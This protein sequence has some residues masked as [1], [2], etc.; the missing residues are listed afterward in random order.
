M[1]KQKRRQP[2]DGGAKQR[3]KRARQRRQSSVD[4]TPTPRDLVVKR[5]L[6][7]VKSKHRS[8]FELV[9]NTEKKKKLECLSTYNPNPPPGFEYVPMGNPELTSLCKELSREKDLLIYIVSVGDRL[10]D[11]CLDRRTHSEQSTVHR[12][13]LAAHMTRCGYHFEIDIVKEA[14]RNIIH[15]PDLESSVPYGAPE[16]IPRSQELYHAQVNA[17]MRDLFPRIPHTDRRIIIDRAF[18]RG[19]RYKGDKPVGLIDDM[20]LSRRI[21]LAVLAHIRHTYTTYD[22]LLRDMPWSSARRV[23]QPACLDVIVKWRGDE[24][25]G[26]DELDEILREVVIISDSEDD[27]SDEESSDGSSIVEIGSSN[28][29]P[30]ACPRQSRAPHPPTQSGVDADGR[31][32]RG[33]DRYRRAWEDAVRRKDDSREAD[34]P[35]HEGAGDAP[36]PVQEVRG[37][38]PTP[39]GYVPRTVQAYGRA[40]GPVTREP[41]VE[42]EYHDHVPVWWNSCS[43]ESWLP[44]DYALQG[45]V[46]HSVET[47]SGR[48]YIARGSM[49][50][51]DALRERDVHRQHHGE[52]YCL[53]VPAASS[54]RPMHG[55]AH[56]TSNPVSGFHGDRSGWAPPVFS[57]SS[58][59]ALSMQASA[60]VAPP[61]ER[62]VMNAARPG[63]RLNPIVMEDRGGFY[64]R[65]EES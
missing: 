16:P 62:I 18:T 36:R 12:S 24:E 20:S 41:V 64:E 8:Y 44:L 57:T 39:N 60:P 63:S 19:S 46:F 32:R 37:K 42:V 23:I 53:S 15:D 5:P 34:R 58:H 31:G 6:P 61:A 51:Y 2:G 4:E 25:N 27:E 3:H 21:Q 9:E 48:Q 65:I 56:P 13:S 7:A 40:P 14:R 45:T 49:A 11:R 1:G 29:A 28:V 55:F 43:H 50:H 33:F 38:T 52:R 26:R 17:A 47:D 54:S 10:S 30:S 22:E 35:V 59:P